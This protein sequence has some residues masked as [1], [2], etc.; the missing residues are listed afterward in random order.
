MARENTS[1]LKQANSS[2]NGGNRDTGIFLGDADA[3]L[4]H[5]D[6]RRTGQHHG[7]PTRRCSVIRIPAETASFSISVFPCSWLC[8]ALF[9][10]R[11]RATLRQIAPPSEHPAA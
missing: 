9:R 7:L 1:L 6:G 4:R 5:R 2:V 11:T 8:T 3:L 10:L